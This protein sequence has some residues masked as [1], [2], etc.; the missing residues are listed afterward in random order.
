VLALRAEYEAGFR[1]IV[2]TGVK[3]GCFTVT[4]PR[5]IS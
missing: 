3:E 5:L 4:S 2:D 1:E